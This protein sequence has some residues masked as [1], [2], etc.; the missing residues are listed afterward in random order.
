MDIYDQLKY[1]GIEP[2]DGKITVEDAEK[3]L[4]L[5]SS[6]QLKRVAAD[7]TVERFQ[8]ALEIQ[9]EVT[10]AMAEAIG[11]IEVLDSETPGVREVLDECYAKIEE[12]STQ[13]DELGEI[14]AT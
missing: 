7:A 3:L 14:Y 4:S 11:Q 8:I 2:V 10:A 6:D 13:V 1:H 12:L 9:T 5:A